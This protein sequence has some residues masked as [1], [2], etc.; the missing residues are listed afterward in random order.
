MKFANPKLIST[1]IRASGQILDFHPERNSAAPDESSTNIIVGVPEAVIEYDF[2][3]N[4]DIESWDLS[5]NSDWYI[6]SENSNSGLSSFR[7]GA[8]GDNQQSTASISL[9]ATSA[10]TVE[11]SYRV[12]S[13]YS[14]SGSNFYDGLTFSID[15][16]QVG[17]YQPNGDGESPWI[18]YSA[19]LSP[20]LHTL[21]W[22][23]SKDGG[24]GSTDCSNTNCDDAAFIDDF[25]LYSYVDGEPLLSGDLNFDTN[26]DVLDI[27]LLVNFVLEATTPGELEFQ[28]GDVNGDGILNILDIVQVVNLILS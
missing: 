19:S 14:P 11:F 6:T 4:Q 26:V 15:G 8:I 5:G 1:F 18:N 2:E 25:I 3:D 20:G 13:E 9:N 17:Q 24:G 21:T 10:S 28:A 27:V 12:S 22:T 23:F 7:S 16:S